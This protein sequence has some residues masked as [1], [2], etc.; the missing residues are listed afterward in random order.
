MFHLN[1]LNAR[2]FR[3]LLCLPVILGIWGMLFPQDA[4]HIT[5]AWPDGAATITIS[6]SQDET[7]Q[8]SQV[9]EHHKISPNHVVI[10]DASHEQLMACPGIGSKTAT[11]I[12]KERIY[13][14]FYDWRDLRT[15]VKGFS[16]DKIENLKEA[17]VKLH[18]EEL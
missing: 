15:R 7:C 10:N 11:L 9:H 14:N 18:A 3:F 2:H 5:Q 12:L 1:N 17:G 4:V 6:P 16:L 13:G 8:V